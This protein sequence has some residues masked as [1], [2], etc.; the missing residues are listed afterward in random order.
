MTRRDF[1]ILSRA[2]RR[3]CTCASP[4]IWHRRWRALQTAD[5]NRPQWHAR[6]DQDRH[7]LRIHDPRLD[8][9]PCEKRR[10]KRANTPPSADSLFR[11]HAHRIG[12]RGKSF[13]GREV[14][15]FPR[16]A[17]PVSLTCDAVTI[18]RQLRVRLREVKSARIERR[19]RLV[20]AIARDRCF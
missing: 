18:C 1:G 20:S 10:D 17:S 15:G 8:R 5:R 11:R 16:R 4:C 7:A 2:S 12:N 13:Q 3:R 19:A 9:T 14:R 6:R